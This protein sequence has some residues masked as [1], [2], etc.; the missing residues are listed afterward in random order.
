MPEAISGEKDGTETRTKVVL[1][2]SGNQ[3][4]RNVEESDWTAGK[5]YETFPS[6]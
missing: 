3:L 5:E 4:A 2:A 1:D 6:D